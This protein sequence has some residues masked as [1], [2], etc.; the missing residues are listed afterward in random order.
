MN[1]KLNQ[2]F[3]FTLIAA[4][5]NSIVKRFYSNS[6]WQPEIGG[7]TGAMPA[8]SKYAGMYD[9]YRVTYYKYKLS[10]TNMQPSG[11][12]VYV[13]N[14]N[15][16]PG[17]AATVV[18]ANNRNSQVKQISQAGGMDRCIIKGQYAISYVTGT[19]ATTVADSFR[20]L[21]NANPADHTYLS[22][23][24]QSSNGALLSL[25]ATVHLD[26]QL[27]TQFYGNFPQ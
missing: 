19:T 2:Q 23:G 8:F 1:V 5:S 7:S 15:D 14:T 6:A 26:L 12:V 27:F 24:I 11:I 9:F 17:T 22:V 16:D 3:L 20:S 18:Y 25:G 21:T 10:V 4:G 13:F